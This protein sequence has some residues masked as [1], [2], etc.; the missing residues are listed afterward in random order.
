MAVGDLYEL[1]D[2]GTLYG[3]QCSNVWTFVQ[4]D[5]EAF[6]ESPAQLL[7]EWYADNWINNVRNLQTGDY[8]HTGIKVRNMFDPADSYEDGVSVAG[9]FPSET[10]GAPAY[11]AVGFTLLTDNGAVSEGSKRFGGVP[12]AVTT[13]GVI[14]NSTFITNA[15]SAATYFDNP[16]LIGPVI[17]SKVFDHVIV[18]RV[19]SGSPGAYSYRMPETIEELVFGVVVDVIWDVI[20]TTQNSRKIGVGN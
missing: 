10:N 14:T 11:A 20:M 7:A 13:D 1:T 16:V 19:R 12:N 5:A 15:N 2:T 9:N 4:T 17:P 3:Q 18:K 8:V 6:P